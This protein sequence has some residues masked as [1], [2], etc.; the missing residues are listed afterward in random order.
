M[1]NQVIFHTREQFEEEAPKMVARIASFWDWSHKL[2][3][4]YEQW[5][6]PRS[7]SQ[8]AL[9]RIWLRQMASF[10]STKEAKYSDD[11]MHDL[12]RHKFLGYEDRRIGN[13]EIKLQLRSTANGRISKQEMSEYM[14]KVDIWAAELGCYLPR[15]ED[16]E[17][18]KYREART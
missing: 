2:V 9:Y 17:Y 1:G 4:K 12:M 5:S 7:R 6:E 15:P 8:L 3:L 14:T 10:F 16:N 11:D 18:T 13:T